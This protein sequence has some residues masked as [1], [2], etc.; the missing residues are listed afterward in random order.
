MENQGQGGCTMGFAGKVCVITGGAKGIGRCLTREF[1]K[2][3]AKI[4]FIDMDKKAGE[5]NRALLIPG[6]KHSFSRVI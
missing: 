3:G 6:G 1:A 4:A 5:E 2:R